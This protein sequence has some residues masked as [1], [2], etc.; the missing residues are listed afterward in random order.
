MRGDEQAEDAAERMR[1]QE[2]ELQPAHDTTG[3]AA[4]LQQVQND[5]ESRQLEGKIRLARAR[6]QIDPAPN[7]PRMDENGRE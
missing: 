7:D 3:L 1:E 4:E 6:G 5:V 2:A